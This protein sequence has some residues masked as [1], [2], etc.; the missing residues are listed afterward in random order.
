MTLF[1][2]LTRC[3]SEQKT[4]H[5]VSRGNIRGLCEK[6]SAHLILEAAMLEKTCLGSFP[7]FSSS[8]RWTWDDGRQYRYRGIALEGE[9][10]C[11][12]IAS[13][14]LGSRIGREFPAEALFRSMLFK[15]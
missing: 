15:A 4:V 8:G 3:S 7:A 11:C 13:P 2:L 1:G 9:K 14:W 6:D 10:P 12:S 5:Q